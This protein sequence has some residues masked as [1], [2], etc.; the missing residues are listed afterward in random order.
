[1]SP[2]S[3]RA[4]PPRDDLRTVADPSP[5]VKSTDH[6]SAYFRSR[7]MASR[8]FWLATIV[9]PEPHAA[10]ASFTSR[11]ARCCSAVRPRGDW[12]CDVCLVPCSPRGACVVSP[13]PLLKPTDLRA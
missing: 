12:V 3:Y 7:D 10:V 2:T 6:H 5:Q 4:A 11:M 8:A 9:S 13:R 1:M